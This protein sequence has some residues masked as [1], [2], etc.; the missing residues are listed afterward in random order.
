MAAAILTLA[1]AFICG[2]GLWLALGPRLT[3]SEESEQNELL[4]L[5]LYV[6]AILPLAFGVVFFLIEGL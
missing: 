5:I 1:L 4:N 3:L 2:G 6:G